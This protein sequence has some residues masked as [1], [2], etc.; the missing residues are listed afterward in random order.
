MSL[1]CSPIGALPSL[2][3]FFRRDSCSLLYVLALFRPG[4]LS[5]HID[6][7]KGTAALLGALV[8]PLSM[9]LVR[10][11]SPSVAVTLTSIP[12]LRRFGLPFAVRADIV[13]GVV[14]R[15]LMQP[16]CGSPRLASVRSR[17]SLSCSLRLSAVG[18][19]ESSA[20]TGTVSGLDAAL[21]CIEQHAALKGAVFAMLSGCVCFSA[22]FAFSLALTAV[23]WFS[24]LRSVNASCAVMI[25]RPPCLCCCSACV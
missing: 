18:S 15:R 3:R 22:A 21:R 23:A 1:R 8:A 25:S 12:S 10:A 5:P 9:T 4:L 14:L 6:V 19:R 20:L 7:A 24:V 16:G 2:N 13:V 17:F 11:Q